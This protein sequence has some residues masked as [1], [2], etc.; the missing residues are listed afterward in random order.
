MNNQLFKR[1]FIKTGIV[2]FTVSAYITGVF[3]SENKELALPSKKEITKVLVSVNDY[4]IKKN[5]V[6]GGN[7]WTNAVYFTGC[8]ELYHVYP[9]K[10]Y[11]DYMD[12]WANNHSWKLASSAADHNAD[13][14][15]CGQTYIDL[16]NLDTEKQ[17]HKIAAIKAE[18]D[19]LVATNAANDDW[20][21]VDALYMAM[22]LFTKLY[23]ITGDEAYLTRMNA[24]YLDTKDKR[25]L[26]HTTS[27]LW[28][29]DGNQKSKNANGKDVFWSRGNGWALAAL[30]RVLRD[31]PENHSYRQG[32]I[33]VFKEMAAALKD[34]QRTD[35]FWNV[36][37]ID[38]NHYGGPETS[39]TALFTY[40]L[41][42]GINNGILDAETYLPVVTRAWNGMIDLAVKEDGFVGYIQG[43]GFKPESSQPVNA[44]SSANFGIGAFLLAGS[45]L[46]KLAEGEM[47]VP[48]DRELPTLGGKEV[49]DLTIT[50]STYEAGTTNTPDKVFDKNFLTRWSA[51]GK[52]WILFE[53]KEVL[54]LKAVDIALYVGDTRQTFFNIELSED[55]IDFKKVFDGESSGTTDS[56]ERYS[57]TPQNARYVR[58]NGNGNSKNRWNSISEVRII[59]EEGTG[60]DAI[61]RNAIGK[62]IFP[63]PVIDGSFNI[64]MTNETSTGD[65]QVIITD[66]TGRSLFTR[67]CSPKKDILRIGNTSLGK[68][69]YVVTVISKSNS[70]S[71]MLIVN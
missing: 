25:K 1:T 30:A 24:M 23:L 17:E 43:A 5:T 8:M 40:G 12:L 63:N 61:Q 41:S 55:G 56:W 27:H 31:L 29:R 34:V 3:A 47:P 35:G 58:I 20:F 57:F 59:M 71:E 36:S 15:V 44:Q 39:G 9:D 51:E 49:T 64:D 60:I 32:Y 45:E 19:G 38:P 67:T 28:Y 42:W 69:T 62:R 70:F 37:L 54:T 22:P 48:E 50:A 14:Q 46:V 16:Y 4:Y 65:I 11:F 7:A 10:M 53:F 52:Q 6:P 18:I 2:L 21:W 13:G 33:N 68:G 26:Y 66:M